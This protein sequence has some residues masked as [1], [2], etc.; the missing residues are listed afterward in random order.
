MTTDSQELLGTLGDLTGKARERLRNCA[1]YP[2]MKRK[3]EK[4]EELE[5]P[6][7]VL[8]GSVGGEDEQTSL[9]GLH[10]H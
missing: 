7:E 2:G 10:T 8:S 1:H 6:L 5:T 9:H 3:E 4:K